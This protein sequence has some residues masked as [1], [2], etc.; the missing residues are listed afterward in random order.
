MAPTEDALSK[1]DLFLLLES[2]KNSVEMNTLISQQLSNILDVL[3]QHQGDR[4]EIE[5]HVLK[6]IKDVLDK[7]EK[8]RENVE[9]HTKEAIGDNS[10]ILNRINLLYVAIGSI[11]IP[12]ALLTIKYWSHIELIKLI[13]IKLGVE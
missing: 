12:I 10:K 6:D 13:A 8:T 1:D 9:Q 2:Y 3:K 5:R 4:T 11:F 7:I